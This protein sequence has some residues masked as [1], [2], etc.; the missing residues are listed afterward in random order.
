VLFYF[1]VELVSGRFRAAQAG[2]RG[3]LGLLGGG[4]SPALPMAFAAVQIK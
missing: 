4:I 3:G 1:V 2:Y